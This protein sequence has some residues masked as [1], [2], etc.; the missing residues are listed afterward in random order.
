MRATAEFD[1]ETV[2]EIQH[3]HFVF[4]FLAEQG[5][6]ARCDRLVIL[7]AFCFGGC[8]LPDLCVDEVFDFLQLLRCHCLVMREVEAQAIRCN[9]RSFLLHVIAQHVS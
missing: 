8:I 7:H 6:R 1:R 5:D 2:A 3:P 9:K 4:V